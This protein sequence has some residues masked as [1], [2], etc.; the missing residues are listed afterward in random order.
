VSEVVDVLSGDEKLEPLVNVLARVFQFLR[1]PTRI[2][3]TILQSA[4]DT[5]VRAVQL[6]W[7]CDRHVSV[8]YVDVVL[9]DCNLNGVLDTVVDDV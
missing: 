1:Q 8:L 6:V 5:L 4:E 9:Y 7:H 2:S 3:Y